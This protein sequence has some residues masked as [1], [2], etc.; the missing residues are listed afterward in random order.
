MGRMKI[1]MDLLVEGTRLRSATA[2]TVETLVASIKAVG[3]LNP[4]TVYSRQVMQANI[5]VDGYGLVAGLHRLAACRN[6]GW[7]EI[8]ANV[9]TLGELER[10]IAECDENLCGTKLSP[11]ERA[12]FTRRRKDA[13]EALHPETRNGAVGNGRKKVRQV[14]EAT[15]RFTKDTADQ[16]GRSER[17]VQRDVTRAERIEASVLDE[18]RGTDLDKGKTLDV[19]AALPKEQQGS[20]LERMQEGAGKLVDLLSNKTSLPLDWASEAPQSWSL[21]AKQ[22]NGECIRDFTRFVRDAQ[23]NRQMLAS[24]VTHLIRDRLWS[25]FQIVA[26]RPG[27]F[28]TMRDMLLTKRIPG[29]DLADMIEPL[30]EIL[31]SFEDGRKALGLFEAEFAKSADGM[32]GSTGGRA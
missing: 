5:F 24:A 13:Y 20:A 21:S 12:L 11:A 9:V 10:Q 27:S 18:V 8:E 14:G 3:L 17:V 26:D 25:D 19:L 1:P 22:S 15:P 4:I 2:A 29:L 30:R 6:L 7:T 23:H 31:G 16:S 28:A 32:N